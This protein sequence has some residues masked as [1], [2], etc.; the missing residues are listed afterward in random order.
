MREREC[1]LRRPRGHLENQ[2]Q[3]SGVGAATPG[4]DP[5]PSSTQI[6]PSVQ[7]V[8]FRCT[9]MIPVNIVRRAVERLTSAVLARIVAT[10]NRFAF[11]A[12]QCE[13]TNSLLTPAVR[14]R[15]VAKL[16]YLRLSASA[17]RRRARR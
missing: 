8:C 15:L 1:W 13:V 14:F 7:T 12:R 4:D 3:K 9:L 16:P 10:G 2:I 11:L 5:Y 6:T 17:T